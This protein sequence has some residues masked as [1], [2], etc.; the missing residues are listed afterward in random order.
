MS[1]YGQ[2][3]IF[4]IS[5]LRY[6]EGLWRMRTHGPASIRKT[7]SSMSVSFLKHYY[8]LSITFNVILRSIFETNMSQTC[9]KTLSTKNGEPHFLTR[10]LYNDSYEQ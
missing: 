9:A 4:R 8:N 3:L 5:T 6:A 10:A 2:K 7:F 1:F